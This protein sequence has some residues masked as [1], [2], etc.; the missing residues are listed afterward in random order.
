[1]WYTICTASKK[2]RVQIPGPAKKKK[3]KKKKKR[4]KE[5][6]RNKNLSCGLTIRPKFVVPLGQEKGPNCNS[7]KRFMG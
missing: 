5:K 1:M 4:R 6:K 7:N 2:A 3:K